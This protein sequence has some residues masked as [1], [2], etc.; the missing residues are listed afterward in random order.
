MS[1]G[2]L[3]SSDPPICTVNKEAERMPF[4]FGLIGAGA[5]AETH[6]L[7]MRMVPDVSVVAVADVNLIRAKTL[8]EQY[9]ISEVYETA[10]ELLAR[11]S[12][13]AVAILTPH[14]LHLPGTMA[15]A[16]AGK[17]VLVEKAI[18]DSV[19]AADE[20]IEVCRTQGVTLGGIF[21][22]RFTPA[23]RAL[24]QA[25]QDESLGRIFLASVSVKVQRSVEYY[26]RAPWRS[27]RPGG[28]VLMINAIHVL[29]LL[30]WLIGMP[31]RLLA[32]TA[33]AVH[34]LEAEDLATGLLEWDSGAIAVLQ[35]TTAAMP[36][37][38]PELEI[39]GDRGTAAIFESIGDVGF[40]ASTLHRRT[41]LLERWSAY[42]S[43]Y[44]EQQATV[45]RQALPEPHAEQIRDFVAAVRHARRPLVDG[46]EARKALVIVE[47][48]RRSAELG[49]WVKLD[50]SD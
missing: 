26:R 46:T 38:P 10:E 24:K 42:A 21:Q 27:R 40:W 18:A 25:V 15:A 17:H 9:Q 8:A 48:L 14:H 50:L 4:R 41:P 35:A 47:A 19:A 43:H 32:R 39:H 30:Q 2:S 1:H 22:N 36:E 12:L 37:I 3:M 45:P 23:A 20:M 11:S 13:D 34:P 5:V 28:G 6:I 29:D 33:T 44:H 16:R 49:E 7:A 31:H